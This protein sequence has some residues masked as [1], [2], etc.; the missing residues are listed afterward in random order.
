MARRKKKAYRTSNITEIYCCGCQTKV[1]AKLKTGAQLYHHRP[2][3]KNT[4]Y[5]QC[6]DCKAFVGC[7]HKTKNRTRPLGVIPTP[8]IKNARRH[9]HK[10]IDPLWRSGKIDRVELYARITE[11]IGWKYH[12]AMIRSVEEARTIYQFVL[13]LRKELN[14]SV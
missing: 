5:W 8:E 3:L 2:D 6:D 14:R 1:M 11:E 9:I 13:D 7:H 12:T 4:P 10:L